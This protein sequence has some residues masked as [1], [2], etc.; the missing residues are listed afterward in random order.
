[1]LTPMVS[2]LKQW[3]KI[4]IFRKNERLREAIR[5]NA[6]PNRIDPRCALAPQASPAPLHVHVKTSNGA[7]RRLHPCRE[8]IP[9]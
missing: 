1:M 6:C 5:M 8:R 9:A 2:S 7:L 4:A 3:S